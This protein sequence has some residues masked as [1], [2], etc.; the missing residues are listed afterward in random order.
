MINCSIDCSLTL[1]RY[2]FDASFWLK[3]WQFVAET[4]SGSAIKVLQVGPFCFSITNLKRLKELY[5]NKPQPASLDDLAD[6]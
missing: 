6:M 3:D 2:V 4:H 5:E 1:G